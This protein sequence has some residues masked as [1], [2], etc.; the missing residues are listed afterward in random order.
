[1]TLEKKMEKVV[2][3]GGLSIVLLTEDTLMVQQLPPW[4]EN[5]PCPPRCVTH[6][7]ILL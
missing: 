5:E 4:E 6:A 7:N 1:M 3:G 2:Q